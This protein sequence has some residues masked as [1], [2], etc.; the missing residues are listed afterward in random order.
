M[1]IR[2]IE[3]AYKSFTGDFGPVSFVDG[4][5]REVTFL[6]AQRIGNLVQVENIEDGTNPSSSQLYLNVQAVPMDVALT[7]NSTTGVLAV[8]APKPKQWTREELEAIAD[9]GGIAGLRQVSEPMGVKDV[10]I[11]KLIDKILDAQDAAAS[12]KSA[13]P[14]EETALVAEPAPEAPAS[15]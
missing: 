10:S 12:E 11:V 15:E 5:S 1:K 13:A 8:E 6:E 7:I 14:V 2:M 9:K 3:D 4:V